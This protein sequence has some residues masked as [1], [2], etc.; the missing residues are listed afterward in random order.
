MKITIYKVKRE[1]HRKG[2]T[3]LCSSTNIMTN[4]YSSWVTEVINKGW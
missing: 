4:K 2:E 1:L 3:G